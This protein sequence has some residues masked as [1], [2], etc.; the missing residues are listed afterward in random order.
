MILTQ[1][2]SLSDITV[3]TCN[4]KHLNVTV[5]V[6]WCCINKVK[7]NV[8]SD[9]LPAFNGNLQT[10]EVW[11]ICSQSPNLLVSELQTGRICLSKLW[12]LEG[13]PT[14]S[15]IYYEVRLSQCSAANILSVPRSVFPGRAP[16]VSAQ[17]DQQEVECLSRTGWNYIF[18]KSLQSAIRIMFFFSK[19]LCSVIERR[20]RLCSAQWKWGLSS[21]LKQERV[22]SADETR[23]PKSKRLTELW[24]LHSLWF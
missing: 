9:T 14:G 22:S 21:F 13:S 16:A 10:D 4:V 1:P 12:S 24:R 11:L 5:V 23:T 19:Q 6:L 7:L 18:Y 3:V 17:W 8:E 20:R 2:A 15:F